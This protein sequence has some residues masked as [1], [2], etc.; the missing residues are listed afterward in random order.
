MT[1]DQHLLLI[2]N[3]DLWSHISDEEYEELNIIHRFVEARKDEY[4]YFDSHFHNKLYFLKQG[5]IKLGYIDDSGKEVVKEIIY[6][7]EVF[8]QITLERTNLNGEFARAYKSDVSLCAFNIHDFEKLLEKKPNIAL[9]FSKQVGHQLKQVENRLLNLLRRDVPSR[10]ANF[11]L[12]MP[13]KSPGG[14]NELVIEHFLTH[15]DMAQLIGSSRQTVTT[16]LN[17][18]AT[19]QWIRIEK[20]LIHVYNVKELQKLANV[21]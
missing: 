3:Y 18:W 13:I 9:R 4:L 6:K 14:E 10:L 11:L 7:G 20:G 8:G 1:V 19:M 17:D 15:E 5:C 16:L 21:S 2:R 12:M